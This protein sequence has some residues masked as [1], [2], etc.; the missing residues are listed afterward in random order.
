MLD[1]ESQRG[2]A[3]HAVAEDV[4]LGDAK[5]LDER[6]HV[7]SHLLVGD[8]PVDIRRVTMAL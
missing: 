2:P 6:R 1:G 4:G 3:A 8:G 7:I 5:V